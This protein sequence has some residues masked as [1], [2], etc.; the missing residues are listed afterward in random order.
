MEDIWGHCGVD[1]IIEIRRVLTD[2]RVAHHD[3]FG[4]KWIIR[5]A[6]FSRLRKR[7][8][9]F[10]D[11]GDHD[12]DDAAVRVRASGPAVSQ[13]Y[14]HHLISIKPIYANDWVA[15]ALLP[16]LNGDDGLP[17]QRH[18]KGRCSR[19]YPWNQS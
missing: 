5:E 9:C 15:S 18:L 14:L 1:V 2:A 19:L 3:L 7:M 10:I 13:S 6:P 12:P 11:I 17:E 4:I 8:I 16:T